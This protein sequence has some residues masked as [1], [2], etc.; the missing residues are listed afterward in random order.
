ML[1]YEIIELKEENK[2]LKEEIIELKKE[3]NQLKEENKLLKD[4]KL[5]CNLIK[6]NLKL[7]R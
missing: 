2:V 3:N 6:L 1:E 4:R 7:L 5:Y